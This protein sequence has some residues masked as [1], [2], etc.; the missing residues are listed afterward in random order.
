MV[1]GVATGGPVRIAATVPSG[2]GSQSGFANVTVTRKS[3]ASVSVNGPSTINV[4]STGNFV[5]TLNDSD[6]NPLGLDGRTVTWESSRTDVATIDA[7]TGVVTGKSPGGTQIK[8]TSEGKFGTATLTV[9]ARVP[10]S[11]VVA[12]AADT[13]VVGQTTSF[14]ATVKDAAGAVIPPADANVNVAV[15]RPYGRGRGW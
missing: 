8:A 14:S 13:I 3:V 4:G 1:T 10:A 7:N 2:S 12:P 15:D 6:G 11:I 5:A 9:S